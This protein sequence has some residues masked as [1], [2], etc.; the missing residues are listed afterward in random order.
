M[1]VT[2]PDGMWAFLISIYL[3]I[4]IYINSEREI[5][6]VEGHYFN[7]SWSFKNAMRFADRS[8]LSF[9]IFRLSIQMIENREILPSRKR[10]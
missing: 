1:C 4:S 2:G 5:E 3:S 7:C 8:A 6:R 10:V 9:V